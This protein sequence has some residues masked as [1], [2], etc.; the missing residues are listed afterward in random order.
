M[1][2]P[3]YRATV[4]QPDSVGSAVLTPAA[5]AP[6][7]D[8][9]KV[10]SVAG[11]T[12]FQPY[13]D[14]TVVRSRRLDPMTKRVEV[15]TVRLT[16]LDYRVGTTNADRWV[17][18]FTADASGLPNVLGC[19]VVVEREPTGN[20]AGTFVPW[21]EGRVVS[22][23]LDGRL[24]L[25]LDV[26]ER[27]RDLNDMVF[28]GPP[29]AS[30]AYAA[31]PQLWPVGSAFDDDLRLG[32]LSWCYAK[33]NL[34]I[35]TAGRTLSMM[36]LPPQTNN[37]QTQ[38]LYDWLTRNRR[39]AGS[40]AGSGYDSQV[41]LDYT[42][43]PVYA[44]ILSG[45]SWNES[46]TRRVRS[47]SFEGAKGS[48]VAR[49]KYIDVFSDSYP[50]TTDA[51]GIF[52]RTGAVPG[53]AT[54]ETLL[55]RLVLGVGA[56]ASKD[57]PL[58]IR[59]VHPLVYLRD[60][61]D[62]KFS[63]LS[64]AGAVTRT[65]PYNATE[66][67][68]AIGTTGS[69]P[70]DLP[71]VRFVE[72]KPR[73]LF[74]VI[75]NDILAPLHLGY[76][77]DDSGK[78]RIVDLRRRAALLSAAQITSAAV[79][80]AVAPTWSEDASTA[81]ESMTVTY[82]TDRLVPAVEAARQA[83][84]DG[85]RLKLPST[86]LEELDDATPF[87]SLSDARGLDIARRNESLEAP[88]FR[89]G[90]PWDLDAVR[91][92][93]RLTDEL[94]LLY[95]W[96]AV[97][98]TLNLNPTDSAV[99][100]ILPGD[101]RRV[102]VDELPSRDTNRR[103]GERLMLAVGV[104]DGQGP[105]VV[106]EFLDAGPSTGAVAAPTLGTPAATGD[107][108]FVTVTLGG[109][110]DPVEVKSY[111]APVGAA[112]PSAD[113]PGWMP[114]GTVTATGSKAVGPLPVRGRFFVAARSIP[115]R[116]A[117]GTRMPSAWVVSSGADFTSSIVSALTS[118]T[119]D[120]PPY[121]RRLAWTNADP[122]WPLRVTA[123]LTGAP[124][125]QAFVKADHAAGSTRADL[126]AVFGPSTGY[127]ARVEPYGWPQGVVAEGVDL[128]VEVAWTSGVAIVYPPPVAYPAAAPVVGNRANPGDR[129]G[130]MFALAPAY[131][132]R[133]VNVQR[134]PDVSGSPG[135][136]DLFVTLPPD[137]TEFVD[138]LP[139]DGLARWYK[140]GQDGT[141]SSWVAATPLGIRSYSPVF[142]G[143]APFVPETAVRVAGATYERLT[144]GY[145]LVSD[146]V[147]ASGLLTAG[148]IPK[149]TAARVLA[150]SLLSESGTNVF[151]NAAGDF[152]ATVSGNGM[153][154]SANGTRL[155]G[156]PNGW[157]IDGDTSTDAAGLG[158]Y[159]RAGTPRTLGYLWSNAGG[160]GILDDTGAKWVIRGNPSLAGGGDGINVYAG[161]A[162]YFYDRASGT[163]FGQWASDGVRPGA[164]GSFD[165]GSTATRWRTL[166][167][168]SAD[169]T[170]AASQ[171][172]MGS[173]AGAP[174]QITVRSAK[175]P[176]GS[177]WTFGATGAIADDFIV[178]DRTWGGSRL[179]LSSAATAGGSTAT[180]ASHHVPNAANTYDLGSVSAA[181]RT[182]YATGQAVTPAFVAL[183]ASGMTAGLGVLRTGDAA[184]RAYLTES[185]LSFGPG[186]AGQDVTLTRTAAGVL[187][188]GGAFA[189]LLIARGS[190]TFGS[191]DYNVPP[192]AYK[193]G[194]GAPTGT[195]P[196]G[197][198]VVAY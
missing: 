4:Y 141:Y 48:G 82:P 87:V 166:Y 149:A 7:T 125:S 96:G 181:W 63:R 110:G 76:R 192:I 104:T 109:A 158:L 184:F 56:V 193:S 18:A 14:A 74:D 123:R 180:W 53:A 36:E 51:V 75:E 50:A 103:G 28:V 83:A 152:V 91:W 98:V 21:F 106:V 12:G 34:G 159:S 37:I 168:L 10:A 195:A 126:P 47:V 2:R 188:M 99:A 142:A 170:G 79:N 120:R 46:Y 11:V 177:T 178:Y 78:F 115:I 127:T 198:L 128:S 32:P 70:W 119:G 151:L 24:A 122:R 116:T 42:N 25:V 26:A 71:V 108:M 55:V 143:A 105:D 31:L 157:Q 27:A 54:A 133:P 3:I 183:T 172:T 92:S 66:F 67:S 9:F 61:L 167:G 94:R 138:E 93:Q 49:V 145:T 95:G 173:G 191:G 33:S 15:G 41:V 140:F 1:A 130:V 137:T 60:L 58:T 155:Y 129:V 72:P 39:P 90:L 113:A 135:T 13:L 179:V 182:I 45:P 22:R 107:T 144:A 121:D 185:A 29:H 139:D 65:I 97:T 100:G 52:G 59:H 101:W 23:A 131:A 57:N 117:A 147:T 194:T 5:G 132:G 189:S 81:F 175:S 88:G 196:D 162:H 73:K 85:G 150:D 80:P 146:P 124:L 30:V 161:Q 69:A 134:A 153:A 111:L 16:V 176:Y 190:F 164:S 77:W 68:D 154:N 174:G 197:M 40:F 186:S 163:F 19:R 6:H 171:L 136:V 62:G 38:F 35:G 89:Q 114:Q 118:T 64:S 165:L 148:R 43:P 160:I 86:G 169:L 8:G 102:N 20:P 44:Q 187:T 17:T 112:T 156:R 84:S